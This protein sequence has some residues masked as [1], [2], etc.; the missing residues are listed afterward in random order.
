MTEDLSISKTFGRAG[1][2][3]ALI[4]LVGSFFFLS[5]A[6][7]FFFGIAILMAWRPESFFKNVVQKY[8]AKLWVALST[9]VYIVT[10]RVVSKVAPLNIIGEGVEAWEILFA[11]LIVG[12]SAIVMGVLFVKVVLKKKDVVQISDIASLFA[13]G[14]VSVLPGF[15]LVILAGRFASLYALI[16]LPG[17]IF[18]LWNVGVALIMGRLVRRVYL[19]DSAVKISNTND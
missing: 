15:V 4:S 12:L 7:G 3:S 5:F 18:M 8:N 14:F 19:Q 16:M 1:L 6:P 9:I 17:I 13:I 11:A 2:Y 10:G